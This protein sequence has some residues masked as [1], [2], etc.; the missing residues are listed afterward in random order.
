VLPS[1]TQ[2]QG[3]WAAIKRTISWSAHRPPRN[4][5]DSQPSSSSPSSDSQQP[6]AA[7]PLLPLDTTGPINL[8][9]IINL[10]FPKSGTSS[11]F[12]YYS[13]G[14]VASSHHKCKQETCGECVFSNLKAGRAPLDECGNYAFYGQLDIDGINYDGQGIWPGNEHALCYFPQISALQELHDAYPNASFT[15]TTRPPA[16]WLASVTGWS[17]MQQRLVGCDLPGLPEGAGKTD[18][19]LVTWYSDHLNHVRAFVAANPS[20][21]PLLEIEIEGYSA[22]QVLEEATGIPASCWGKANCKSSCKFW[23]ELERIEAAERLKNERVRP[24]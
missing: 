20:H 1:S 5:T 2:G 15:L 3:R 21:G 8:S 9:P 7:A 19:E 18:E 24:T 17:N 16:H 10:G 14:Q 6:H 11:L 13:C 22:G 4:T 12:D 23:A